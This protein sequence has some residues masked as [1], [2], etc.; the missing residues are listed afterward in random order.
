MLRTL[1]SMLLALAA[2][3]AMPRAA[4]AEDFPCSGFSVSGFGG[5]GAFST[6]LELSGATPQ[7]QSWPDVA[8]FGPAQAAIAVQFNGPLTP[9]NVTFY[10]FDERAPAP[11]SASLTVAVTSGPCGV[12][13]SVVTFVASSVCEVTASGTMIG[14]GPF[15]GVPVS[16]KLTLTQSAPQ[17]PLNAINVTVSNLVYTLKLPAGA[18]VSRAGAV[19][20]FMS[21]RA[22]QMLANDVDVRARLDAPGQQAGGGPVNIQAS[23]G[24]TSERLQFATSLRQML[25]GGR[26]MPGP[27]AGDR[28]AEGGLDAPTLGYSQHVGR[29]QATRAPFDIWASG[30]Y[31][32]VNNGDG[33]GDLTLLALGAD[34]RFSDHAL[35]GV[36]VQ[37]D[38]FDE[39]NRFTRT[40]IEG[41]GWMVGPYAVARLGSG[42]MLDGKALFGRSSNDLI[43][44]DIPAGEFSTSRWLLQ[45]RLSS[46]LALAHFKVRP[47]VG[48]LYFEEH[49]EAFTDNAGV[50]TPDQR[51][52]IGRLTFGPEIRTTLVRGDGTTLT[53]FASVTGIWDF[54]RANATVQLANGLVV[55]TSAD[56]RARV[57]G[58]LVMALTNGWQARVLGFYDG[59]GSST[60]EAYGANLTL[61]VKLN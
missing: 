32:R 46:D 7:C 13:G 28:P 16:V 39:R 6:M 40:S 25:G 26:P 19:K 36:L 18:K 41:R 21:N 44:A 10:V 49:Q 11:T 23:Q 43:D 9:S 61:S 60:L 22:D 54:D 24:D 47:H 45:G 55:E 59:I 4:L 17:G 3:I 12:A 57:E 42:L 8:P 58:G 5:G 38:Q 29:Q 31:A 14:I 30:S 48:V 15:Q 50:L 56:L 27:A 34:Y 20:S 37:F 51:I 53:P 2:L 35:A 52:T 1:A 33:R